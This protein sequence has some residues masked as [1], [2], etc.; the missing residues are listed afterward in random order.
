MALR[1][2]HVVQEVF[3]PQNG[4]KQVNCEEVAESLWPFGHRGALRERRQCGRQWLLQRRLW[5]HEFAAGRTTAT[6]RRRRRLQ[7]R[8]KT[9]FL[10]TA[11][12]SC[13]RQQLLRQRNGQ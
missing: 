5:S 10:E 9:G 3:A 8:S 1:N 13:S 11:N 2:G 7:C 4:K 6:I 12:Q